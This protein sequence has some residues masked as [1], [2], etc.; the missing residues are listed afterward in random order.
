MRL[1]DHQPQWAELEAAG[2]ISQRPLAAIRRRAGAARRSA[3]AAGAA[4]LRR[5][6]GAVVRDHRRPAAISGISAA[7][8]PTARPGKCLPSRWRALTAYESVRPAVAKIKILVGVVQKNMI[9][10]DADG[11]AKTRLIAH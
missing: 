2:G 3:G 11:L 10:I 4:L 8:G 9:V 1:A 7:L 6:Q 5:Q